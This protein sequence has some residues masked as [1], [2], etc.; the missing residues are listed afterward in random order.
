MSNITLQDLINQGE[1]LL[2][3]TK[4]TPGY[5]F[6]PFKE[7]EEWKRIADVFLN[8]NYPNNQQSIDFHKLVQEL[9]H[10]DIHCKRLLAILKAIDAVPPISKKEFDFELVLENLF[11]RFHLVANQ[12]KRRHNGR[13]T[14]IIRDEYDVQDLLEALLKLFFTDVRPEEWCPSYAG[15]SKRMDFLLKNEGIIIEVKKTRD[16]LKDKEIGE[17]LIIDIANYKK[18]PDCKL[19]YCFVYDPDA[20]IR[21]PRGIESDLSGDIDGLTV[22]V[23]VVPK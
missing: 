8:N 9:N 11:E 21:N 20:L 13:E 15:S 4:E 3:K 5:G 1:D 6:V 18:H 12:L 10:R 19:L 22:R 16:G 2:Q 23:R 17:Q 7:F 14:L